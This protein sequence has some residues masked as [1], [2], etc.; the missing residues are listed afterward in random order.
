MMLTQNLRGTRNDRLAL[1][2]LLL[3]L[4]VAAAVVALAVIG[5][6]FAPGHAADLHPLDDLLPADLALWSGFTA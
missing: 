4:W 6:R 2:G 5:T 1:L 3:F